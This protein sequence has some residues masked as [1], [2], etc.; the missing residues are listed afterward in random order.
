MG[1]T[2]KKCNGCLRF[3]TQTYPTKKNFCNLTKEPQ[4]PTDK[5]CL[6]FVKPDKKN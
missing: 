3:I 2:D 5:A 4:R 6:M 1:K